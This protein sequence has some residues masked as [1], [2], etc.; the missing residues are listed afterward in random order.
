MLAC[1]ERD[2]H[3][4]IL[5]AIVRVC[6]CVSEMFIVFVVVAYHKTKFPDAAS[7]AADD[8]GG[9]GQAVDSIGCFHFSMSGKQLV[10]GK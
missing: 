1:C 4:L 5:K 3:K 8:D 9:G 10:K 2:K 6:V 7:A